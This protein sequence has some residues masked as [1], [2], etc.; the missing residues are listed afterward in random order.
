MCKKVDEFC[1]LIKKALFLWKKIFLRFLYQD[2]QNDVERLESDLEIMSVGES[3]LKPATFLFLAL[4][5]K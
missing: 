1:F 2:T 4:Y 3:R 5:A